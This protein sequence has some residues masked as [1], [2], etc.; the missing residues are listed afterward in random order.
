MRTPNFLKTLTKQPIEQSSED[1]PNKRRLRLAIDQTVKSME[2]DLETIHS[3]GLIALP[4]L[5]TLGL[6][7]IS[8]DDVPRIIDG[9]RLF[10]EA[11]DKE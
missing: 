2:S 11:Y 8:E 1:G 5:L 3:P 4:T 6:S 10:I 9:L 7:Q